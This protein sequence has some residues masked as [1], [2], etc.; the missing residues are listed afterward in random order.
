[1]PQQTAKLSAFPVFMRVERSAVVIVGNGDAAIAKARLISQSSASL[2]VVADAPI[3]ALR[4]WLSTNEATHIAEGYWRGHLEGAVLVFAASGDEE[5]D[6]R[7]S[8]DAREL[9]IP[10]NSVDRPGLRYFFTP[11]ILHS[12]PFRL[13]IGW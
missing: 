5:I 7:V 8:W 13:A 3:P 9:K 4:E 12:G 1:M 2:R 11:A 10:V 6:R